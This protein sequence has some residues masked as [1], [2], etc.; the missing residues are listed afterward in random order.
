[1]MHRRQLVFCA[2]AAVSAVNAN[3]RVNVHL[4]VGHPLR[5]PARTVIL[6]RPVPVVRTRVVYAAPVVWTRAV[7][8]LPP[9]DRLVWEDSETFR[10]REDWVDTSFNVNNRGEALYFRVAGRAQVD[11]AEVTFNNGQTQV[12]DFNE[13]PLE[14]GTYRLLDFADGRHVDHVR[15]VAR[16]RAPESTITVLMRK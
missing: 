4:G 11:F 1:M 2:F 6:R 10:R 5:R 14:D 15:M 3:V 12:V 9:R 13:A 8:T 7:V 16:S